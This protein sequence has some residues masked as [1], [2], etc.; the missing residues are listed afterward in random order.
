MKSKRE[1]H[2]LEFS[3]HQSNGIANSQLFPPQHCKADACNNKPVTLSLIVQGKIGNL[4]VVLQ[5]NKK[6]IFH[7]T[8]SLPHSCPW[9]YQSGFSHQELTIAFHCFKIARGEVAEW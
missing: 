6:F 9:E 5:K 4:L 7:T 2:F 8:L 1:Q 3:S